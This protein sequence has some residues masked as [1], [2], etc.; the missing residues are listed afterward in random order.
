MRIILNL[1]GIILTLAKAFGV[2]ELSWWIVLAPFW[3]QILLYLLILLMVFITV[4]VAMFT[5]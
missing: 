1:L 4:I 5:K 2:L 3:I